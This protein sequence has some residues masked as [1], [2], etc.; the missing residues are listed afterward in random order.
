MTKGQEKIKKEIYDRIENDDGYAIASLL[1]VYS[2]QLEDE[3][4][5]QY[6]KYKNGQGF[7]G[8]D[9]GFMSSLASQYTK[10]GFLSDRQ[11][12]AMKRNL[13]KYWNQI[14][15]YD[16][17]PV[18]LKSAG[19]N[20][21]EK[22]FPA[23]KKVDLIEGELIIAWS[24][25]KGDPGF[26]ETLKQV[27]SLTG[28][29]WCPDEVG[30][31]WKCKASLVNLRALKEWDFELSESAQA[32][33]DSIM[34]DQSTLQ[35]IDPGLLG[36]DLYRFQ[37]QGIDFLNRSNGR[38]LIGSEMGLGKTVQAIGYL[39][40]NPDA[41]PAVVVCPASLKG[42]WKREIRKWT[43][44]KFNVEIISGLPNTKG[45]GIPPYHSFDI[46]TLPYDCHKED[47]YIINY[48]ILANRTKI[49][50][51]DKPEFMG[52]K[53][54]RIEIPNTG[55]IDF[56][57]AINPKT[58]ILDEIHKIK[59]NNA[60]QTKAV[61]KLAK[62]CEHV[63]GLSG[64]PIINRPDE[65][66]NAIQMINPNV[67]PGWRY[68]M[69]TFCAAYEGQWGWDTKGSSNTELLHK[70]MTSTIMIR[71]K[72]ADVLADLPA[73]TRSVVPLEI[74]NRSD[75]S[76]AEGDIIGWIAKNFGDRAA[77]K[78]SYAE[79]LV[80]FE[81]L[82]QLAVHGKMKSVIEWVSDFLL[83]D[84][85]LIIFADHKFVVDALMNAFSGI[86]VKID[87]STP[88]KNRMAVVDAFQED[89]NVRL[90]VG[91]K[92][93]KEGLTL[94]ISSNVAFAELFWEPGS[95]DQA[96]DRC[97]GRLSDLHGANIWYLI[98]ENTVEEKIAELLDHKRK[99]LAS[100]LDG[101]TVEEESL[102]LNLLD[103]FK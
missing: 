90:F 40:M 62:G 15:D 81:K 94:T 38:A 2:F 61:K 33:H 9:A 42:N 102:L 73:K 59:D 93:A 69:T 26:M 97:Y 58:L 50:K 53:K 86:A 64:T 66:Y 6:T 35:E 99:V 79:A 67:F 17:E 95:H 31:P 68:Y 19:T 41:C 49:D 60:N 48:D 28:T 32:W 87:G 71:H 21:K 91:T 57:P 98:A 46:R 103:S 37:K 27:K 52:G 96:E 11:I 65:F 7:N 13:K 18:E 100:V 20:E 39:N 22:Q 83:S 4:A 1:H 24:F 63:I 25:P 84:E 56:L 82:K 77:E 51:T 30:K 76:A 43:G 5:D 12:N 88:V 78:A 23:S 75:Y 14:A 29:H 92:A 85:K 47:I 70:I 8:T 45:K 16:L 54:K 55:W 10:K 3:K 36:D 80:E 34:I 44:D 89:P 74:D 72:K 101:E